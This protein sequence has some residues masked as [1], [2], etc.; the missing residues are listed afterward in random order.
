MNRSQFLRNV[1]GA[2]IGVAIGKKLS[3]VPEIPAMPGVGMHS[4][5]IVIPNTIQ[6]IPGFFMPHDVVVRHIDG[7]LFYCNPNING[8]ELISIDNTDY[9]FKVLEVVTDQLVL[10]PDQRFERVCSAI[11]ENSYYDNTTGTLPA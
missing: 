3:W 10:P 7:L 6:S 9:R 5:K 1:L 2:T 8:I 11:P 4:F